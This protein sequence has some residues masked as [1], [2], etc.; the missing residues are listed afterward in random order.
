[1]TTPPSPPSDGELA[2]LVE[3]LSAR[4]QAGD[5]ISW[6]EI[7]RDHPCCA[8]ELLDLMPTLAVLADL[9]RSPG[10]ATATDVG[11]AA[12]GELGDYRILR[13]VGRGG[14]GVVY[15]AEQVSLGRRV[16]LK[17]LPF[18]AVL[19][20]RHLQRFHNE[21]RAAA[22]LHHP[23]V[24]PV[25]AVG[26]ERGVHYYAMQFIDGQSLAAVIAELRR[27][28]DGA[29]APTAPR[30]ETVAR[31]A[32]LTTERVGRDAAFCRA[33]ARLG[34]QAA[35]ALDYAHE[36]GVVHRD[37]KP[38]N[39]LLDGR[40]RV[41][42]ADFGLARVQG[43]GAVTRTGDRVGTLRY[44]SPEQCG[45]LPEA[46]DR[47]TDVYSLGVTLYELLTLEPAFDSSD[48]VALA[49]QIVRTD[50]RPPRRLNPA[51][52]ADLET[53]VLKAAAK[54]ATDRYAT[55]RELADDLRSFLE[56]RPIKARPPGL[57]TRLRRWAG[58]H[59]AVVLTA[60]AALAV[61]LAAAV[62]GLAVSYA[63]LAAEGDRT[64][65]AE[66][67]SRRR[68]WDAL[69]AQARSRRQSRQV[70]QQFESWKAV[71]E[72][73]RLA[74]ELDLGEDRARELRDEAIACLAL[75]DLRLVKGPWEGS[76][77][78]ASW[79]VEFDADL[80][81][82]ARGDPRGAV[83]VHAGDG[84]R[85]MARLL[86]LRPAGLTFS[87]DG[88]YLGV[89][90]PSRF[91]L[92]DWRRD[93]TILK[94]STPA[95]HY[96]VAFRPDGRLLSLGRSDGT[97]TLHELP[98]G[99]ETKRF[100]TGVVPQHLAFRPDG[101]VLAVSTREGGGRVVQLWDVATGE[102]TRTLEHPDG[103]W[104]VA[105]HEDGVLL[106]AACDD[107]RVH[108]WDTVTG[109]PRT[110]LHGH[111]A[112]P[113]R[114]AFAAGSDLLLSWGWDDTTRLWNPWTG[115]E[116][117]RVAGTGSQLS[118]DGRRLATQAGRTLT[119]WEVASARE[120]RTLP[121][122]RAAGPDGHGGGDVSPDGR[123]LALGTVQG[124]R[125][126]DLARGTEL[127]SLPA[128]R[129]NDVR[130]HPSGRELFTCGPAGLSRWPV[131][132]QAGVLRVGPPH[133]L[134]VTG[135]LTRMGLDRDGHTLVVADWG[136]GGRVVDLRNPNG[137]ARSFRHPRADWA[138]VSP[139]GRWVATSTHHGFGNK[140][141]EVATGTDRDL[142]PDNRA[143][144]FTFSP[145]GRWLV[146]ATSTEFGIRAVGSW[147]LTRQIRRDQGVDSPG[148]AAFTR[149][150]RVLAITVT[151]SVVQLLDPATG[152]HLARLQ[153]P[154]TDEIS[155]LV[156][157][158]DGGRLV[159]CSR[160]GNARVWD[161][162]GLRERLREVGLD[163]DPPAAE[164]ARADIAGG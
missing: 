91:V 53:I 2:E 7:R 150:G 76:P 126:W 122:G 45:G 68:L 22:G 106:A 36:M 144:T 136:S 153:A 140:V 138:A 142:I 135:S 33:A 131:E 81:H 48:R 154:D 103:V 4:L 130:F 49:A 143:A 120:Y 86:G 47:R 41:W 11:P 69:V 60:A 133:K 32:G 117:L 112:P 115:Q 159:A 61:L 46:I 51:V 152:R 158:P 63:L 15:E 125:L 147:E 66:R 56:D 75:A 87:P 94:V 54:D 102:L 90:Y 123:W 128:A 139:D 26:C 108:V 29:P 31:T 146:T 111:Q 35:E 114:V 79:H 13:E 52:P 34:L 121:R 118:H 127:A 161:L 97:L 124:V 10:T 116:L 50:P 82:Y 137:D 134:P 38:G 93:V 6:E 149:D 96:A 73:A 163:W 1:V 77:A 17:V 74:R 71:T 84:D 21:A 72:A 95:C 37:V 44:M 98:G 3:L 101:G 83:T 145:D 67:E 141:W 148:R 132:V 78:G 9:P 85:V 104:R 42:V 105:W 39:L 59:R 5:Q 8:A 30:A 156:F 155:V 23:N 151:P 92:W 157:S 88:A 89:Q 119:L 57:V 43:D 40:G 107:H 110:V 55:A 25:H 100:A 24:V 99:A 64:R 109:R 58:R 80:T 12:L 70:G 14:M 27:Q 65:V 129:V 19:D 18:A 28:A 16:A 20:P 164:P 162:R 160:I 113:Q 62:A